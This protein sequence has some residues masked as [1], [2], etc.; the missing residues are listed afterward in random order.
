M[1]TGAGSTLGSGLGTGAGGRGSLLATTRP[2]TQGPG[3][4]S[5]EPCAAAIQ[6][7]R[8]GSGCRGSGE[9]FTRSTGSGA[10]AGVAGGGVTAVTVPVGTDAPAVC[11]FSGSVSRVIQSMVAASTL[12]ALTPAR[13][14]IT[15]H[16]VRTGATGAGATGR[17]HPGCAG[18][19]TTARPG[20]GAGAG[21]HGIS[22]RAGTAG[23]AGLTSGAGFA[24]RCS[25][26]S[27]G[28]LSRSRELSCGGSGGGSLWIH[29]S[30]SAAS[31]STL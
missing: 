6:S 18:T 10:N 13:A 11:A 9:S 16:G 7:A 26:I 3:S 22:A 28:P 31:A 29:C 27:H 30:S 25:G 5:T 4:V 23:G 15:N 2:G 21:V 20:K 12:T 24:L 19:G 14:P 8:Y 17:F 1:G